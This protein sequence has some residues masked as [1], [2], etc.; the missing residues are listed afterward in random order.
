MF[1]RAYK[2][3]IFRIVSILFN[4]GT[5]VFIT[6]LLT[7]EDRGLFGLITNDANLVA[8]IFN[9]GIHTSA[10]IIL[11]KDK[12]KVGDYLNASLYLTLISIIFYI[13]WMGMVSTFSLISI[14][15]IFSIIFTLLSIFL[16]SG[17]TARGKIGTFNIIEILKNLLLCL[18]L[19]LGPYPNSDLLTVYLIYIPINL[20]FYG[21]ITIFFGKADLKYRP[22]ALSFLLKN[23][24]VSLKSYGSCVIA[25][26]LYWYAL[27]FSKTQQEISVIS[28][29]ELGHFILSFSHIAYV[30]I[31]FSSVS[32]IFTPQFIAQENDTKSLTSTFKLIGINLLL[33]SV[34]VLMVYPWMEDIFSFL[35]GEKHR[36]CGV[37]FQKMIPICY[38]M[39][40]LSSMAPFITVLKMP[41]IS[42]IAPG[43]SLIFFLFFTYYFADL[44]TIQNIIES[45][46]YAILLWCTMYGGFLIKKLFNYYL[47]S[48]NG[49]KG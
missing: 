43:L 25:S 40:F 35:Y 9:F 12:E 8:Q 21:F 19:F 5:N 10:L 36:I 39:V 3:S 31:V 18:I 42:I 4:F 22:G 17:Y 38:G 33:L 44:M 49:L 23:S 37:Y 27:Y 1:I 48:I 11:T 28:S 13:I 26:T 6:R 45:Y 2:D 14:F 30:M 24:K 16:T 32:L 34:G 20:L 29:K 41:F 7:I 15:T 47:L 46:F